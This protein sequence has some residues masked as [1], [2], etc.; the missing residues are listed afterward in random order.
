MA[1]ASGVQEET[2]RTLP[3]DAVRQIQWRYADRFDLQM[4][5][6]AAREVARGPVARLVA[7][8]ARQTHE[9]TR[10]KESLLAEF[11]SSG[12]TGQNHI[13]DGGWV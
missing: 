13:I 2:L 1:A 4:L 12:I 6:Q 8:G 9:W 11:D 3:G 7:G 10:E 5:V